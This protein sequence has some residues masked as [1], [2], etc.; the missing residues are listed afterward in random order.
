MIGLLLWNISPII[1]LIVLIVEQRKN[2]EL[3]RKNWELT[4]TINRLMN[5]EKDQS[6]DKK[7]PE[8]SVFDQSGAPQNPVQGSPAQPYST[9]DPVKPET[10]KKPSPTYVKP[11]EEQAATKPKTVARP[12]LTAQPKLTVQPAQAYKAPKK[13]VSTLNII[14]ILG[15]LLLSLSGFI[16]AI[17]A[18][19]R[20]NMFMKSAVLASFSALF[21]GIHSLT[22]RK[23]KLPQTGRIFYILGSI[24]LPSAVVAAGILKVFG[25]YFSFYGEGRAAVLSAVFLSICIPFFKGAHDYKNRFFSAVFC[26]SFSAW[27]VSAIWQISPNGSITSLLTAVF[28]LL[29]VLFEPWVQGLFKRFFGDE[30]VFSVEWNRFTVVNACI[31]SAVSLFAA[32]DGF[33]SLT[34]FAV[35]SLCFL[36]RTVTDKSGTAG[37]IGF[38][39][40]ITA[41]MLTGFPPDELSGF[42]C[43]IAATALICA[44]LSVMGIFPE[45]LKKAMNILGMFVAGLAGLCGIIENAELF[46]GSTAPSVQLIIAAASI[47]AQFLVF[48][49]RNGKT[50]YKAASFGA[51]LWLAADVFLMIFGGTVNEI[52]AYI[53][54][55]GTLLFYFAAV[56][57]TPLRDKLYAQANDIILGIYGFICSVICIVNSADWG[58]VILLSAAIILALSRQKI[59]SAVMCP[60]LTAMT[61][62]PLLQ[63]FRDPVAIAIAYGLLLLYFFVARFTK[64]R[65]ELY[66]P[67]LDIFVSTVAFFSAIVCCGAFNVNSGA[68]WGFVILAAG[69]IAAAFSN[70]K[71]ISPKACVLLTFSAFFPTGRVLYINKVFSIWEYTVSGTFAITMLTVCIA[72]ALLLFFKKCDSYAR[73]YSHG[74]AASVPIFTIVSV[75]CGTSDCVP[76]LAATAYTVLYLFKSAFPRGKFYCVNLLNGMMILTAAFVGVYLDK[77][78]FIFDKMYWICFPAAAGLIIFAIM[79]IGKIFGRFEKTSPYTEHF[80]W[81]V[82]AALS[83]ITIF[84]GYDGYAPVLTIFGIISGLCTVYLSVCRKNAMT[85]IFPIVTELLV[86]SDRHDAVLAAILAIVFGTAG[87]LIF[88]KKILGGVFSDVFSIAAFP[89]A[90]VMYASG[91]NSVWR[92]F[93]LLLLGA[94]TANLIRGEQ[95][96]KA[97]SII[98]TIALAFIFPLW[99]S[100][101][102]FTVPELIEVQ[103]NLLP[104]WV[105][106]VIL[107]FIWRNAETVVYN[108]SFGAAILSLV[109]LFIDALSS[110]EVFDAV[111]IGIVIMTMLGVSFIIK[112]KR[113]FVLAVASMV[114][115]AVLLSFSQ[116]DS[117]AWLVYLAVAGA[118][119]I[120]LGV[121]NE[122]KKQQKK[123]GEDGKLSRFMSDWT[124]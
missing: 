101:P 36:T 25:D 34:A 46:Q 87:R 8:K 23:L 79:V 73:S 28:A 48:A 47:Y 68:A 83:G 35:F 123:S 82:M 21:F 14:L 69:I 5:K 59:I 108:I 41:A 105:F 77:H 16:F 10:V 116:R 44:V 31:L 119:L 43:I 78:V 13:N 64:M 6:E 51:M 97:N 49:L 37:A 92:W 57:F 111:F 98:L 122:L 91:T 112:R 22:E 24:F 11:A 118:A 99:W 9:T 58:L 3:K 61:V 66:Y 115:S 80:L 93:A 96:K 124:W 17:A 56:R 27:L 113:W 102:F 76:I 65:Q 71:S 95:S 60:L 1:L 121:V 12:E 2:S 90:M 110:K 94:L 53:L 84:F 26:Y 100:E 117:I 86:R 104:L 106:C 114:T 62:F 30:N 19:G 88:R 45:S 32:N 67:I 70:Q 7:V 50:A 52:F 74:V 20:L 54:S 40:F 63:S 55:F 18:W 38:A 29:V 107:R 42:T 120:A 75:L 103:F 72:A 39:F 33:V 85:A 109:I 81:Y 89:M 4:Q 15:A